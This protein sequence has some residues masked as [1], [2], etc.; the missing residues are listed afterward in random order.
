MEEKYKQRIDGAERN[1]RQAEIWENSARNKVKDAD[2]KLAE[3][4]RLLNILTER[5]KNIEK[6]A[7]ER[8]QAMRKQLQHLQEDHRNRLNKMEGLEKDKLELKR[9]N[10][11]LERENIRFGEENLALIKENMAL[12]QGK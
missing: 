2:Q 6:D 3:V 11:T 12:K 4:K 10:N 5:E 8:V 9:K 1:C 7:D